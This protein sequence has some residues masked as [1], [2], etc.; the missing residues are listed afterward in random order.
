MNW[1]TPGHHHRPWG[2]RVEQIVGPIAGRRAAA[3]DQHDGGTACAVRLQVELAAADGDQS[4]RNR[5]W[6][7]PATPPGVAAWAWVTRGAP[8]TRVDAA[9]PAAPARSAAR[10][11]QRRPAR[12]IRPRSTRSRFTS[13]LP[14]GGVSVSTVIANASR[15]KRLGG[16]CPPGTRC[17]AVRHARPGHRLAQ[18]VGVDEQTRPIEV[19]P[20]QKNQDL[21]WIDGIAEEPSSLGAVGRRRV[22]RAR[23]RPPSRCRSPRH[24][25]G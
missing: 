7:R 10:R 3:G 24:G 5:R 2:I 15:I 23:R 13:V 17:L 11:E 18:I 6:P 8:A 21:V 16:P 25:D 4:R 20:R 22:F 12:S 14:C 9:S 1:A 19:I